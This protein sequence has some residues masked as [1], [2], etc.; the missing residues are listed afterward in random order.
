MWFDPLAKLGVQMHM[1]VGNHDIYYK[2]TLRVNAP[3]EL[4][5]GYRNI[6]LYTEP[7]TITI[8]GVSVLLLP[9]DM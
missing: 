5:E 4:L 1:L 3:G 8:G 9:L 6:S 7:T 2:N